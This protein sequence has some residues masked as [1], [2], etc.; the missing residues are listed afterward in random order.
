ML[1]DIILINSNPNSKHL[2][3]R[4]FVYIN[5]REVVQNVKIT[6]AASDIDHKCIWSLGSLALENLFLC[7]SDLKVLLNTFMSEGTPRVRHGPVP[8]TP[9]FSYMS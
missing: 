3:N 1:S 2:Q 8:G 4:N 6:C 7:V 5:E 9:S